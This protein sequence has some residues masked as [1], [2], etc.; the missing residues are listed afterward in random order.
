M[1]YLLRHL[2]VL[3]LILGAFWALTAWPFLNDV[4]TGKTPQY[5]DLRVGDYGA[6][7]ERVAAEVKKAIAGLPGWSVSGSGTGAAGSEI[8]AVRATPVGLKFDVTVRIHRE[9]GRTRLSVRS[10]SRLGP[11]DFG[12][13][14]RNIRELLARVDQEV[15]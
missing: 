12:Q 4:E 10:R 1:R 8:Q 14:A 13:N 9:S 6:S 15:F 3:A 11:I 5:P 7:V 2:A